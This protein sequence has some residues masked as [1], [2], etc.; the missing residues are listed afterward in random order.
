MVTIKSQRKLYTHL[1]SLTK[2]VVSPEI[3]APTITTSITPLISTLLSFGDD[4]VGAAVA[5]TGE[6]EVALPFGGE[7]DGVRHT[8]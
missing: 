5:S 4:T 3:P 1:L 7:A 6:Q 2:A 8:R